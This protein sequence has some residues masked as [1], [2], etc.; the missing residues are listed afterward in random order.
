MGIGGFFFKAQDTKR[1]CTWYQR[2]L[3]LPFDK[4]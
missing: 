2:Y 3:G 4:K 1:L